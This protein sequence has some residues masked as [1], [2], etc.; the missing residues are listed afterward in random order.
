M[1]DIEAIVEAPHWEQTV[2][3]SDREDP[4]HRWWWLK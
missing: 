1:D 2:D 3:D 4:K